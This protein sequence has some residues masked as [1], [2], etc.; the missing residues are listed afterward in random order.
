MSTLVEPTTNGRQRGRAAPLPTFTFP[1]SGITVELRRLAPGTQEQI[2]HAVEHD[3]E[4]HTDH[5]KPEP[6]LQPVTDLEGKEELVPNAD[7]P[8][9]KK[10]L[11]AYNAALNTE[12][13]ERLIALAKRQIVCEVDEEAVKTLRD[14]MAAVGAPFPE[15]ADDADIYLN[16]ICISSVLDL[17]TLLAYVQ[18]SNRPTE[19]AIARHRATFS[20]SV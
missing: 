13:G 19:V 15:D 11:G 16:R 8:E 10:R 5:P 4:W 1:D 9:Y 3:E 18:G 17:G 2:A 7:E 20:G 14:D 12:I 6:P